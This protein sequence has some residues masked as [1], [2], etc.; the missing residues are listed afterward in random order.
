LSQD[1][2][3]SALL[4][5][6]F[7]LGTPSQDGGSV[8]GIGRR[9]AAEAGPARVI[10]GKTP[11]VVD[12]DALNW[13]AGRQDWWHDVE[14]WSLILTPHTGE[15]A[16]LLGREVES[17]RRD[18]AGSAREA[19]K[20]WRQVVMLKG[21]QA[22]LTDGETVLMGPDTPLSLATAGSG[23]VL[24]GSIGAFLAQGLA[25]MDARA[26]AIHVGI[27][28]ARMVE[29]EY[30]VLGVVAGDLPDAIGRALCELDRRSER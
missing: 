13:L 4:A 10:G 29:A 1:E 27:V 23:D 8:F 28:A 22:V 9:G 26:L 20:T 3:A 14:P 7:G 6:L 15:M 17:I 12:A 2:H 18:P 5:A 24:A 21:T 19:A 30:G 16:R 25:P 11:A